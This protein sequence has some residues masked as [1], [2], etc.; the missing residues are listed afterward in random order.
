MTNIL[1]TLAVALSLAVATAAVSSVALA[2]PNVDYSPLY[3][4][5]FKN[6]GK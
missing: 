3:P 1:K 2:G 5:N 4:D 6:K